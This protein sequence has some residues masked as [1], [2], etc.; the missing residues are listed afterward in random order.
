MAAERWLNDVEQ[1]QQNDDGDRNP[2]K[3]Q[4]NSTH[5]MLLVLNRVIE[6]PATGYGS[7]VSEYIFATL[8]HIFAPSVEGVLKCSEALRASETAF[9]ASTQF[10]GRIMNSIIYLVGL[11][12]VVLF[13]LSLLGLR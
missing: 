9:A 1:V 8:E 5:D 11:V 12:V 6:P 13:V 7:S 3:P 10:G 4:Q 2:H